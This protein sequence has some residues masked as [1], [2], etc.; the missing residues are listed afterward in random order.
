MPRVSVVIPSYNHGRYIVRSLESVLAQS[1]Q[2]FEIVVVDDGSSDDSVEKIRSVD[3][4]RVT[5]EA[6][7]ENRGACVALNAA[8]RRA[9]GEFIAVL[10][11]DDFFL[12]GKLERQVG[13]LD[14]HREIGAV[15]ARPSIVDQR[16]AAVEGH[17]MGAAFRRVTNVSRFE[18][19][20]R[21]FSDNML[22]HP[23]LM[24]RR[25]CY[26]KIGLYNPRLAQLPDLEMWIRL[27]RHFEIHVL[28]EELT[29]F[30]VLDD[31][32]NASAATIEVR[33]R[34]AW[35][36][37]HV[38]DRYLGLDRESFDLVFPGSTA[39]DSWKSVD[40]LVAEQALL[41]GTPVHSAFALDTL[42]RELE[43]CDDE[44]LFAEF[45][46]LT[47]VHDVHNLR[48]IDALVVQIAALQEQVAQLRKDGRDSPSLTYSYT[49]K[50]R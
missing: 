16:G 49:I 31:N 44:S 22:C 33:A 8:I 38:L 6:F 4:R 34:G 27:C 35:E 25:S 40:W 28:D 37:S 29:A 15:F 11:S 17:P 13:F 32:R 7:P 18:W 42:Y 3:D 10:N 20:R 12:P 36:M 23:T 50:P 45:I 46:R 30:R 2:D 14:A 24:V 41:A 43:A 21:L 19:L 26:D 9:R 48:T 5:L 1:Y 47:G 39:D